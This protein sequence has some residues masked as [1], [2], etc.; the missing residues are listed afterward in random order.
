MGSIYLRVFFASVFNR[1]Y[2]HIVQNLKGFT[3]KSLPPLFFLESTIVINFFFLYL[4]GCLVPVHVYI[5]CLLNM[6]Y[7]IY[8][9][10]FMY[11]FPSFCLKN[12]ESILYTLFC[13]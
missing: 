7:D 10:I 4:Q 11:I 3:E 2:F 8:I 12:N 13:I 1:Q 6:I 5:Y 9:Y